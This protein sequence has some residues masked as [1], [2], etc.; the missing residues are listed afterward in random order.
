MIWYDDAD[1]RVA[2]LEIVV[3]TMFDCLTGSANVIKL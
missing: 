1:S 3:S 2:V